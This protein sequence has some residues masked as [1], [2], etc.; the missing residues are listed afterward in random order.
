MN[1]F[2]NAVNITV[3]ALWAVAGLLFSGGA[4]L[5]GTATLGAVVGFWCWWGLFAAV[6]TWVTSK[7][8][9]PMAALGLHGAAML[10][11]TLLPT[12]QP[13]GLLRLG[14]DLIFA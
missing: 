11:L 2:R 14:Y 8:E 10:V 1:A 9:G 13:F 3:L 12:G 5:G 4:I 7:F 6:M